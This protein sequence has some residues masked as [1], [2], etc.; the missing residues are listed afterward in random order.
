MLAA[1]AH[2]LVAAVCKGVNNTFNV[3]ISGPRIFILTVIC[4]LL[5]TCDFPPMTSQN[6][7]CEI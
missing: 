2:Y 4:Y 6:V 5:V 3:I 1:G 7:S